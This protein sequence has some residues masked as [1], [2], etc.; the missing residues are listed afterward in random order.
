MT[1]ADS[2]I[3]YSELVIVI[4][5]VLCIDTSLIYLHKVIMKTLVTLCYYTHH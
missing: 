2:L 4:S 1:S 3:L 5:D